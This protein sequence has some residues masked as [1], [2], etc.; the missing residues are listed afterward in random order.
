MPQRQC[1]TRVRY[2]GRG[3][4]EAR[5]LMTLLSARTWLMLTLLPDGPVL[6]AQLLPRNQGQ[7]PPAAPA[8]P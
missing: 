5:T 7:R 1:T 4:T 3:L 6:P 2:P 8:R